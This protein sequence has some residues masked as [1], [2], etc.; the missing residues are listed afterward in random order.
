MSCKTRRS[1][2]A[3]SEADL[4]VVVRKQE[5]LFVP[6][7]GVVRVADHPAVYESVSSS[8][9]SDVLHGPDPGRTW[10]GRWRGGRTERTGRR[11]GSLVDVVGRGPWNFENNRGGVN[12]KGDWERGRNRAGG[13]KNAGLEKKEI[14][15]RSN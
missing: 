8:H 3:K 5:S 1:E 10:L 11:H 13:K 9:R 7:D 14:E 2:G 4:A 15:N 6:V 12:R